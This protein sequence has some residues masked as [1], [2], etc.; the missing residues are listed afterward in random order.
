MPDLSPH[1]CRD[2]LALHI[3]FAR[4]HDPYINAE[5]VIHLWY[6]AK[7]PSML[8]N[9]VAIVMK[10]YFEDFEASIEDKL[11]DPNKAKAGTKL[12]PLSCTLGWTRNN[13]DFQ[14]CLR[15]DGW[16]LLRDVLKQRDQ[17]SSEDAAAIRALDLEKNSEP[18]N[19]AAARMTHSRFLGLCK[20]RND[21]MLLPFGHPRDDFD[22]FNP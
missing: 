10:E 2:F 20:W 11:R 18:L 19:V 1:L 22:M 16:Q 12:F 8:W 21:G 17:I 9:H 14:C 3:L 7:M 15:E 4:Q 6:S 13:I 5:A